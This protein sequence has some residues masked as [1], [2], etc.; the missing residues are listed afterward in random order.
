MR[1]ALFAK[2]MLVSSRLRL[3]NARFQLP[4]ALLIIAC[5]TGSAKASDDEVRLMLY[6]RQI[7]YYRYPTYIR[8]SWWIAIHAENRW[9]SLAWASQTGVSGSTWGQMDGEDSPQHFQRM[10][11]VET[12]FYVFECCVY[13]T[14]RQRFCDVQQAEVH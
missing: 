1:G 5:C 8:A 3:K 2:G 12:G 13:R 9:W 11:E 14:T 7:L 6:P 10:I 4:A